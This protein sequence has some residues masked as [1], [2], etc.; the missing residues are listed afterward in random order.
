MMSQTRGA[1]KDMR[2]LVEQLVDQGFTFR[3]TKKSHYRIYSP[4]GKLVT[5]LAMQGGSY[6]SI[7]NSRAWLRKAGFKDP[8]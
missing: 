7:K 1:A 4:A 2:E 8:E 3:V 6:R 5:T